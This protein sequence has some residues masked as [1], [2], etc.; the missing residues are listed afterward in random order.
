MLKFLADGSSLIVIHIAPSLLQGLTLNQGH[1]NKPLTPI[2]SPAKNLRDG[3]LALQLLA[4]HHLSLSLDSGY[5]GSVLNDQAQRRDHDRWWAIK[6]C[7][8]DI[9]RL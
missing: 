6:V 4:Y 7:G 8:T 2:L 1:V 3:H 9:T 5:V